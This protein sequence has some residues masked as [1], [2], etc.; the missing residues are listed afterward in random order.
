MP[1]FCRYSH[2][3]L[4]CRPLAFDANDL[5]GMLISSSL[6]REAVLKYPAVAPFFEEIMVRTQAFSGYLPKRFWQ[7]LW[8]AL[9]TVI[10]AGCLSSGGGGGSSSGGDSSGGGGDGGSP[11]GGGTESV[12]LSST[13][14]SPASA[15]TGSDVTIYFEI[16]GSGYD[17]DDLRVVLGDEV[18]LPEI[19]TE[20]RVVF[21]VPAGLTGDQ[22]V[23]LRL[24]SSESN[25]MRFTVSDTVSIVTPRP[26]EL[27]ETD[28][29]AQVAY[30][31]LLIFIAEGADLDA[32]AAAAAAAEGGEVVG[33]IDLLRSRQLRLPT[34]SLEQLEA[35]ADRLK[36]HPQIEDVLMDIHLEPEALSI[37]W[38][39][40]PDISGQRASNRVEEGAQLYIESVHPERDGAVMPFFRSMGVFESGIHFSRPD[41]NGYAADGS[42]RSGNIGLFSPDRGRST[43]E[44]A[45]HGTNVLGLIA[46]ELGD[47]GSAGLLRALGEA[48]AHG[49]INIR[50]GNSGSR[51]I[52]SFLADAIL[53]LDSGA[54]IIN[55]SAGAHRCASF[56]AGACV[57][58]AVQSNGAVVT[59]NVLS[60]LLFDS[61][62]RG[63]DRLL[64]S[65][66]R[67]FPNAMLVVAAGNGNTDTGER[68]VRLFG[69][70]PSAQVL[71]VGAHD[72][73]AA[74][75]R[76]SYSNY[77]ARVDIAAAGR[78]R[79]AW[80]DAEVR[81]TSYAAPLV[82]A[83][84]LAMRSIEPNLT[85]SQVRRMLRETALPIDNNE[86]VLTSDAGVEVGRDVFT[87][88]LS[89]AEV[90]SDAARL[91]K[92]AR[93]NVEGA[94]QAALDARLGR[95]RPIGDPVSVEIAGGAS[96]TERLSVT[97]PAEGAVF[98]RVDIMFLVDV[99]GS[100]SSSIA[101]FKRQAVDLVNAFRAS[102]NDVNTGIASFSDTPI[103]PWGVSS[104]YAFQLDQP[105]SGDAD[106]TI[107]A[108]NSLALRNGADTPESQLE[109]LYQLATGGGRAV[110]GN[111]QADLESSVAG[112]REG[113]LRIIFMATDADFHS[114]TDEE[115]GVY[116]EGYPGPGWTE[117][118]NA[119]TGSGIRVYGL[120]RGYSVDDVRAI[121]EQ[122]DGQVFQLDGS[123][124]DIVARVSEALDTAA[125]VLDLKLVPNGDFAGMVQSISPSIIRDV[126]RGETVS[127]DVTFNRG[128][129]GP[130]EQR[131][132]FRLDVV[133]AETAV[134][135]E[136]PVIIN[137]R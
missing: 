70:H 112:W 92:G 10:L 98:D 41:F 109:A 45:I 34:T 42:S 38:S 67:H 120:E 57:D 2:R 25:R 87:R 74:P 26:D 9:L 89:T 103:S 20:E 30:N 65:M 33:G 116:S 4:I 82:A 24:G 60:A 47:G 44:E 129:S 71:T 55:V 50:V 61:L 107:S 66:S 101:Q 14:V 106:A 1:V 131:F 72:L 17:H 64:M 63:Y 29:G 83:T 43:A 117:T 105:L 59:E 79:S 49:G 52:H 19:I 13:S 6:G 121:V 113:S 137:L 73:A 104:D 119:L 124:S 16:E 122:T 11:G 56:R 102:G 123:S 69:A 78:V 115:H 15:A 75:A 8:L 18:I 12:V 37:N 95:T 86:V 81:G 125:A 96:I 76:E 111:P 53:A 88:P 100:Y 62:S 118:V 3:P 28:G 40:D 39:A 32:V 114:S 127:F 22:T 21:V 35:A 77:G 54:Q 90:G 5:S 84:V 99:S 91:N 85:P 128:R 23:F 27:E 36:A 110:P 68:A 134:I 31:L 51:S 133:G 135:E 136:I 97:L 130:G 126:R 94:I 48:G 132:V 80:N 7:G 108:I 58:G 46:A 93:L